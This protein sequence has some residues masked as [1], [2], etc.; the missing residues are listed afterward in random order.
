[1]NKELF[2]RFIDKFKEIVISPE[3]KGEKDF[4]YGKVEEGTKGYM[5]PLPPSPY[6]PKAKES[7][8]I[9]IPSVSNIKI[10]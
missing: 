2:T 8:K 7:S 9:T 1:M 4:F 6:K 10:D 3:G 5:P